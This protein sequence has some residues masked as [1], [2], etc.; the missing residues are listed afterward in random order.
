MKKILH[1]LLF[2]IGVA[3]LNAQE[4]LRGPYQQSATTHS[5][6]IMWR[7]SEATEGW[8]KI[9]DTPDNLDKVFTG[10]SAI[11]HKIQ[12]T[13]LEPYTRYYY[14]VGY[15]DVTLASGI[16]HSILTNRPYGDTTKFS[17]WAIGDFGKANRPQQMARNAF[18]EYHK[19]NPVDFMITL[20][21][22]AYQN[23]KDEEF[24]EKVF[25]R[26]Y[27]YD[28][29][30]RSLHYYA[31]PGN[32]DYNVI[33]GENLLN[34]ID[35][36]L[37]KGPYFDAHTSF[38]NGEG[39][40]VPSGTNLYYSYDYGHVHFINFN[41]ELYTWLTTSWSPIKGWLRKDLEENKLP[42][43][44]VYFHQPPYTFGSH[45]S[46]DFYEVP[47]HNIRKYIIPILEKAGVD[48]VIAGHS[49]VYE[50]S[51]MINGHYGKAYSFDPE[52][53]LIDGSSGN[54][55]LGEEYRKNDVREQSTLY[56]VMGNSGNYTSDDK[57]P[58]P[59]HPVFHVRDGG[60]DVTGSVILEFEGG[61]MTGK[62]LNKHGDILDKWAVVK[63]ITEHEI[64]TAIR[65]NY[66]DLY[67][68]NAFPNPSSDRLTLE[69][70]NSSLAKATIS[71]TDMS[72]RQVLTQESTTA[73][74]N[75]VQ[76]D[77]WNQ[78][79]AGSYVV[80]LNVSDRIGSINVVKSE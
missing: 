55:D 51:Y 74:R 47:M 27:G 17:L 58:E 59:M 54:P 66:V 32:H 73:G 38:E 13:G 60:T 31:T 44:V 23:G 16:D 49:H 72:G 48:L 64:P 65:E 20:G 33:R 37:N 30:F 40:G 21:D 2:F 50:R 15:D 5:V 18:Y 28:S 67:E 34:W 75:T 14:A 57:M 4:L 24:S 68:M 71:V 61:T 43:V 3:S 11:N 25:S 6:N 29:I 78:L 70:N 9:G 19:E 10:E 80:S 63:D 7:T 41:S 22:N 77:G 8:V 45:S 79:S 56:V 46:D 1:V 39:G 12:I 76:I 26:E 62:Y 35:P 42:W 53:H 52:K 36:T 69:F